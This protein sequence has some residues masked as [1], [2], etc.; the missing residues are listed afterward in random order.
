MGRSRRQLDLIS[1]P[2]SY[3]LLE[4]A[5]PLASYPSFKRLIPWFRPR[6]FSVSCI[7]VN[8]EISLSENVALPS[9]LLEDFIER[10]SHRVIVD[11]CACRK[12]LECRRYPADV[13]C[14]MMGS[15]A[16]EIDPSVRRE[17][18][19]EE[20]LAHARGAMDLGLIPIVGKVR[21]DNLVFGI[22][23]RKHLL[24]ACFCCECCCISRFARHVPPDMRSENVVRLGGLSVEVTDECDG[25]G[26]CAKRCFL[27]E[28][29]IVEGRA[30][31]GGGCAGCGR[32]A[33][34]CKRGAIS[35]ALDDPA[36]I[37][38]ARSRIEA[39]VDFE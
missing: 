2:W 3:R 9:T 16:L 31:I 10:A 20:A 35:V 29:T 14:L 15:S 36:F 38:E 26:A 28:I 5:A 21:I 30:V 32:C 13:G 19:V 6:D 37:D 25:C 11:Y 18:S 7:P 39:L 17:V 4:A 12:A 24:S 23:D 1:R 34:V 33:A 8:E 22:R 27:R